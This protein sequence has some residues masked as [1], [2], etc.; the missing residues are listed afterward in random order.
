MKKSLYNFVYHFIIL[1]RGEYTKWELQTRIRERFGYDADTC[2]IA[3][4]LR[5]LRT[6]GFNIVKEKVEGHR[7]VFKYKNVKEPAHV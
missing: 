6:K 3:A 1:E 2:S 5:E 4:R 7:G